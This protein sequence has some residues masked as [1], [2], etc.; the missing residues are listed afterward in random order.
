MHDSRTER[1]ANR[2]QTLASTKAVQQRGYQGA[3]ICACTWVNDHP[4][5]LINDGDVR[6][7]INDIEGNIF[8]VH[9]RNRRRRNIYGDRFA[10]LKTM[11]GLPGRTIY[12]DTPL[13]DETLHVG[14]AYIAE[15]R[16]EKTVEPLTRGFFGDGEGIVLRRVFVRFE[17]FVHIRY[18]EH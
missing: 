5:R 11:R 8:C 17:M 10:C 6:V 14:P 2:G 15:V 13:V 18:C 7:F 12:E 1:P 4:G 3:A 9:A 16:G